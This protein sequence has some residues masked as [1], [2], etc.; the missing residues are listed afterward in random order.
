MP[1]PANEALAKREANISFVGHLAQY[2]YYNMEQ[3]EFGRIR[4]GILDN[5][6]V[7]HTRPVGGGELYKVLGVD[8]VEEM[9][10]LCAQYGVTQDFSPSEL[11]RIPVRGVRRNPF[12]FARKFFR[13]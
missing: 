11:A 1:R 3:R 10:V 12:G 2:R 6:S 4:T 13:R 9:R 5:V 8:P 7:R